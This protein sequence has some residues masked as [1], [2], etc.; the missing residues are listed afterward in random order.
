MRDFLGRG[1]F[2]K[3][4]VGRCRGKKVAVKVPLKQGLSE[5]ELQEFRHEVALM[6]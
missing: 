4:Y 6:K 1:S 2:G 3:V 5:K